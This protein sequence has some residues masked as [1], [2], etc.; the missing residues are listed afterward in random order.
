[1]QELSTRETNKCP[2]LSFCNKTHNDE[3]RSQC[4]HFHNIFCQRLDVLRWCVQTPPCSQGSRSEHGITRSGQ[5]LKAGLAALKEKGERAWVTE[6]ERERDGVSLALN[7][8]SVPF[9]AHATVLRYTVQRCV[10]TGDEPLF[11]CCST[12]FWKKWPPTIFRFE[13]E[14]GANGGWCSLEFLWD[15]CYFLVFLDW[16]GRQPGRHKSDAHMTHTYIDKTCTY[17]LKDTYAWLRCTHGNT[18]FIAWMHLQAHTTK[19][20]TIQKD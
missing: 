8:H 13:F 7:P 10:Y 2:A 4:H 20:R 11:H 5:V 12:V 19:A 16:K 3:A 18:F 1:M 6:R 14:K 9:T 15:K 17:I